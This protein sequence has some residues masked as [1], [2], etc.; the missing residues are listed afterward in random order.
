M[1]LEQTPNYRLYGKTGWA[2]RSEPRIGWFVGYVET[3]DDTWVFALNI[4]SPSMADLP[5][6]QQVL[7]QAL[8]ATQI[9]P[10]AHSTLH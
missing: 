3:A 10:G 4:D 6:R 8:I 9:L 7:T 5:K 2:A 1:L